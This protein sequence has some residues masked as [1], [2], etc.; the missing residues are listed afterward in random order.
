MSRILVTGANGFVG[1]RLCRVLMQRGYEVRAALRRSCMHEDVAAQQQ[2]IVGDI[3]PDTHWKKAL[4]DVDCV[5]HLAARVHVMKEVAAD[6]L[7]E[8]REVNSAGTLRLAK[9]AAGLGVTRFIY[10]SSIKVNGEETSAHPFTADDLPNP[11]DPYSVSKAEAEEQLR[12]IST[13]MCMEVVIVRPPLVYGPHIKG[14]FL[15]LI[16]LVER[17]LPLPLAI[18]NNRRSMISLTNMTDLLLRCME[19]PEAAGEIFLASDGVEWTTPELIRSIAH[20]LEVPVRLFT[21]PVLFLRLAGRITGQSGAVNRLCDSLEVDISK[22]RKFL[23]WTPPQ[24]TDE[25]VREVVQWYLTNR[26]G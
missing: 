10:V 8:F 24:S 4:Q 2:V 15:R 6:P 7:A 16:K 12:E 21:F 20:H 23:N 9:Q 1:N 3:G 11:L 26:N 18:I 25:G 22:T 14:N 19:H 5:L 17:K 13:R